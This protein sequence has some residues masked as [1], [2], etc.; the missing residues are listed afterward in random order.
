MRELESM[1]IPET[2]VPLMDKLRVYMADVAM[3]DI[4]FVTDD[5][6]NVIKAR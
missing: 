3:E 6:I 1:M 5:M 2:C 4:I